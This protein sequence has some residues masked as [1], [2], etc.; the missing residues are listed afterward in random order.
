MPVCR[1][2]FINFCD[3]IAWSYFCTGYLELE[4]DLSIRKADQ[5]ASL[6]LGLAPSMIPHTKLPE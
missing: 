5:Y 6:V 4:T 1:F 3:L 2:A